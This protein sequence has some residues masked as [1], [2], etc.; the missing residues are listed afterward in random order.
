M[1]NC[2]SCTLKFSGISACKRNFLLEEIV[3]SVSCGRAQA[4]TQTDTIVTLSNDLER[5]DNDS[6]GDVNGDLQ[7]RVDEDIIE[8]LDPTKKP[9][10]LTAKE[11]L[12]QCPI[13]TKSILSANI[14]LHLDSNCKSYIYHDTNPSTKRKWSSLQPPSKLKKDTRVYK[15]SIAYDMT[16]EKKLREMLKVNL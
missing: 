16:K 9:P 1:L 11:T 3:L 15:P 8:I 7:D 13:C 14:N 5:I 12:F 4:A 6:D 10:D 2:P